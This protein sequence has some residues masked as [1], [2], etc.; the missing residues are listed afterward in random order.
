MESLTLLIYGTNIPPHKHLH[1]LASKFINQFMKVRKTADFTDKEYFEVIVEE[2][3]L[4]STQRNYITAPIIPIHKNYLQNL[5][6]VYGNLNATVTL[7]TE[8][9][10]HPLVYFNDIEYEGYCYYELNT[11]KKILFF[12][13]LGTKYVV[14]LSKNSSSEQLML[15][16]IKTHLERLNN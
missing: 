1:K 14:T 2:Q 4:N 3:S 13:V 8:Q 15:D 5:L 16:Y 10:E 11:D 7:C 9:H 12:E 6:K